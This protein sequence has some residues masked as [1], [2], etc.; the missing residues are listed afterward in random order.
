MCVCTAVSFQW[1][2]LR[3]P[4]Y[5]TKSNRRTVWQYGISISKILLLRKNDC[6]VELI[7]QYTRSCQYSYEG[8]LH[9]YTY[10]MVLYGRGNVQRLVIYTAMK[11]IFLAVWTLISSRHQYDLIA[12]LRKSTRAGIDSTYDGG[13]PG[14]CWWT[15]NK[16]PWRFLYRTLSALQSTDK[17]HIATVIVKGIL[18]WRGWSARS[19]VQYLENP[20][21]VQIVHRCQRLLV[22]CDYFR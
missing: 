17:R 13:A 22:I 19:I 1:R 10:I 20:S 21:F 6:H 12:I 15:H 9:K 5:L 14:D 4:F 18:H 8:Y 3:S 2:K 7:L 11:D 16:D